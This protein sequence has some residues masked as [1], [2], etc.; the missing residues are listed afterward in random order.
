MSVS[1]IGLEVLAAT[2]GA[3]SGMFPSAFPGMFP[4]VFFCNNG[5]DRR[6]KG[7]GVNILW[8]WKKRNSFGKILNWDAAA[9]GKYGEGNSQDFKRSLFCAEV[10]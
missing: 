3:F 10:L 2:I 1:F 4:S 9:A 7:I 5:T 8:W 6:L